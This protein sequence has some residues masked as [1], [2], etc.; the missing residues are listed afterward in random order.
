MD[1]RDGRIGGGASRIGEV[2]EASTTEFIAQCYE[3]HEAPAFGSFV[4]AG[5]GEVGVLGVVANAWTGSID[6]GR[7]PVPRGRDE[8]EEEDVYR[9][10]PELPEIL[11]TEFTATVVGFRD[12]D[13][14]YHHRL[15]RRPCRLHSFVHALA[16]DEVRDFT[17]QLDF[18]PTLLGGTGKS[19]ADELVAACV[20]EAAGVRE[21]NRSFV[22][23]AGKELAIL[24]AGDPNRLSAILRKVR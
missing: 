19:P 9:H 22:V 3:L 18:L 12:P 13:G 4:R 5:G 8:A 21:D 20:R 14:S 6:P 23:R 1:E 24:L 11:R 2:V 15:P 7:R 10:N 16:P 17:E